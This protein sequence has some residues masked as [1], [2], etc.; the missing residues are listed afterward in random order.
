[1]K[2]LVTGGSGF[3]GANLVRRLLGDGHEVHL[4]LRPEYEGWRLNSHLS[5]CCVHLCDLQDAALVEQSV[6]A[7]RPDWVF[8]LAAY[9]A[10][11]NQSDPAKVFTVNCLGSI[12]LVDSCSRIGVGSYINTGSSSEYGL[13]NHAPSEDDALNPISAYGVSKTAATQYCSMASR[14]QGLP[15]RTLRLYSVYGPLERPTRL[16]PTLL[17]HAKSGSW[18]PLASAD[19]AHDF[20]Y[21]DDAV[22]A[23]IRA[24]STEAQPPGAIYNI[25]SGIQTTLREVTAAVNE[26]LPVPLPP[27]WG[28][29]PDRPWDTSVWVANPTRAAEVLGWR[30]TTSLQ[31][32]LRLTL[33]RLP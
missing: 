9:G 13:K 8:H 33:E 11:P 1:M 14:V 18:P 21:V 19:A 5:H 20:V 29:M 3:V 7:I 28:S 2:C 25:G 17:H 10:Y 27:V 26:L 32:G 31:E 22:E 30:T 6:G 4:L 23:F 15:S 24:A 12:H 16:I